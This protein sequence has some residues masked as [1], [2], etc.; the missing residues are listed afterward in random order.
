MAQIHEG[1]T[2]GRKEIYPHSAWDTG[3][4]LDLIY[5]DSD[6]QEQQRSSKR[7]N[8]ELSQPLHASS[9]EQLLHEK[10]EAQRTNQDDKEIARENEKLFEEWTQTTIPRPSEP[11][12]TGDSL[13]I[14]STQ[15]LPREQ[16]PTSSSSE[17]DT[18]DKGEYTV[19]ESSDGSN[20]FDTDTESLESRMKDFM[21]QDENAR[22]DLEEDRRTSILERL[23]DLKFLQDDAR[24]EGVL[25]EEFETE[26]PVGKKSRMEQLEWKKF[27]TGL[28]AP[29][30]VELQLLHELYPQ[31]E[32]EK[33]SEAEQDLRKEFKELKELVYRNQK[34]MND[35]L[36]QA[37]QYDT[38]D[39]VEDNYD[40]IGKLERIVAQHL[41]D[42]R[43]IKGVAKAPREPPKISYPKRRGHKGTEI[44]VPTKQEEWE[45]MYHGSL[46][47]AIFGNYYLI[48]TQKLPKIACLTLFIT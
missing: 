1:K 25:S 14:P 22:K 21:E 13:I 20:P 48:R 12:K 19:N 28:K 16:K 35:G 8:S 29:Q 10:W 46:T 42:I 17:S 24:E 40:R 4:A 43:K 38:N 27:R 23:E 32:E 36:E 30:L 45:R 6:P 5:T 18:S 9:M 3:V 44:I 37:S 11:A 34:V 39:L 31:T 26:E 47:S 2:S 15:T 33:K 7:G 41:R